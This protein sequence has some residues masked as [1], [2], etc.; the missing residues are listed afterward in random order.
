ME[1][2]TTEASSASKLGATTLGFHQIKL[3]GYYLGNLAQ[4]LDGRNK[5][6]L[7]HLNISLKVLKNYFKIESPTYPELEQRRV[8]LPRDKAEIEKKTLL[9][10][11]DETLLHCE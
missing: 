4:A 8:V 3:K 7:D 2:L 6:A 10:D 1:D 9:V 11:I 5:R